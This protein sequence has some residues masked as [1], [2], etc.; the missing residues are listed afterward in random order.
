[1]AD[2][3]PFQVCPFLAFAVLEAAAVR[4]RMSAARGGEEVRA[5]LAG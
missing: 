3:T 2:C 1:M 4:H 5:P